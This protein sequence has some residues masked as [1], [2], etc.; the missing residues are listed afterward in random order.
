MQPSDPNEAFKLL[1][2]ILTGLGVMLGIIRISRVPKIFARILFI[3]LIIGIIYSAGIDFWRQLPVAYQ[4]I[5]LIVLLPIFLIV[6]L[7]IVLGADLFREVL[8]NL[9][10]DLLKG[11]CLLLT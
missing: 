1:L 4:I 7:R 9:I 5:T 3:P 2:L 10:Y 6:L 11:S 8:G